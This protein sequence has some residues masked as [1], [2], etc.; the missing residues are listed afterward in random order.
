MVQLLRKEEGN[1]VMTREAFEME[2][3][4]K[5]E[6]GGP[7][8]VNARGFVNYL[9]VLHAEDKLNY[10]YLKDKNFL[11]QF[12]V[13]WKI[14]S[15]GAEGGT[16]VAK[17]LLKKENINAYNQFIQVIQESTDKAFTRE[18]IEKGIIWTD[19][20]QYLRSQ[21]V[22]ETESEKMIEILRGSK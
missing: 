22:P 14:V 5:M 9:K 3:T 20:R 7:K 10:A 15:E 19:I 2:I 1:L 11:T 17:E 21:N 13:H 6:I 18:K 16:T 12:G 8:N 4:K